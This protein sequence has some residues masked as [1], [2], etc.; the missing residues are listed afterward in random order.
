MRLSTYLLLDGSCRDA[1]TFY[2]NVFGGVLTMTTVGDSPMKS[3]LPPA[4]HAKIVNARLTSPVVDISASDWLRPTQTPARGNTVCL[5]L[6][7]G[8][9]VETRA[10]FDKL[11]NGAEVTDPLREMPFGLY[12]AAKELV[13]GR[14][15]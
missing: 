15:F 8:N 9:P 14:G 7:G 5:Y 13:I 6:S 2:H 12:Q 3:T 11:A 10:I 4:M 1:M